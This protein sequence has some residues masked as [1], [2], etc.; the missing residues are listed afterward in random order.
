[1]CAMLISFRWSFGVYFRTQ[2]DVQLEIIA[3]RHRIAVLQ[4]KTPKLKLKAADRRLWV[5]L[6]ECWPRW[7]QGRIYFSG[8][9]FGILARPMVIRGFHDS[10]SWLPSAGNF[11]IADNSTDIS[12][13]RHCRLRMKSLT[14]S[15]CL[16]DANAVVVD[17]AATHES[18]F[19]GAQVSFVVTSAR[20]S[21]RFA[22]GD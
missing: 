4:R 22:A 20:G 7:R 2:S 21:L 9:A 18:A 15:D 16:F 5:W 10:Y 19:P 6:S 14:R 17:R 8:N 1:M 12:P 11:R 13:E 3:M